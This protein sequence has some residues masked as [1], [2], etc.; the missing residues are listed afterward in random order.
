MKNNEEK[1]QKKI[2]SGLTEIEIKNSREHYGTNLITSQKQ[3]SFFHLLLQSLGDPI[4]K[5]LLIALG[6]K[7]IFLLKQFDWFE[8]IGIVI[9][10]FV[11]SFISTISEYGSEKAF[12]KL[13]EESLK[14]KCRVRR[15][16]QVEE[17]P[18]DEVV[19][20]DIVLLE[21]GDKIPAD[22]KIIKGEL[23]VDESSLN[24]ETKEAKKIAVQHFSDKGTSQNYV[25]RGTVVY[26]KEAVMLVTQVGNETIFG[27]LAKE[28]QEKQP[29]SPLKIRLRG[30]AKVISKIGY[31]GSALVAFSYLFSVIVIE[32]QFN[33]DKITAM[34][35]NFPVI[36]GHILYALTLCVTIIVVAVPEGLPMMI[37]LVLSSNMKRMLKNNVLVRKLT[38]IETAGNLN[39]LFTDKTGTLT[40]G[41]LEV[42]QFYTGSR[43]EY[44]SEFELTKYSNFY[45]IVKAS[46]VCNN[47]SSFNSERTKIVGGNITDRAILEFAGI[48][49]D[50][51][52]QKL[53]TIPFDSKNKYSATAI[54]MNGRVNLIKGAPEKILSACTSYYEEN[55]KKSYIFP[56]YMIENKVK[57]MTSRGIRAVAFATSKNYQITDLKDLTFVGIAFIKDDIREEAKEGIQLVHDAHIQTVMITGDN[58]DTAISIGKE[59][60]LLSTPDDIVLTSSELAKKTDSEVKQLLP[61]LRIVARSLPQDKSRLVRLSQELNLVVGM[62]GDGVNDAP[63]LKKA[64]VGFAMGSGT[65][66]SKE[67]SDIVILDDN[68]L[69]ISK[70]ILFGRTIFKSIRKFIILQLTINACAIG[71][72]I[73]GPF[74]GIDT[75]VTVIQ[76]LW[77]N[78]VMDTL[79][80]LAFAF[81]PPLLEYMNEYPKKKNEAIMNKYMMN[82]II[83]NGVYSCLL[84][85]AF[86][87]V[88]MIKTWFRFGANQIY[89]MTAFFGLFIFVD[90]FNGFNAR[91]HR[92]NIFAH[93]KQ[94]KMFIFIMMLIV[95]VQVILIYYG[96]SLFRTAGLTIKEFAVMLLL[97]STVIPVDWLRKLILRK[98]GIIGGV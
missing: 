41:K 40:K 50:L 23:S 18:I 7:M 36:T 3:D 16:G 91:T 35:T 30:L 86:L 15:N 47:A 24:G 74:I 20:G 63:A 2:Y 6:I 64:D 12:A 77:I 33:L 54:E 44:H 62:T 96:G 11:A 28:I 60:G 73:I 57:S 10:I 48:N 38:G 9:A 69:S 90:I 67:A 43:K 76:M 68:F 82:Q 89:L 49:V 14:L 79:A 70:A 65:E 39:I 84:C 78:M 93:L 56:K 61:N 26:E 34:I 17:I 92:L 46:M 98:Q 21:A 85:I 94:N 58:K 32:N 51:P 37:T 75:P 66:V 83:V 45:P 27:K 80:G 31:I 87:K 71:L 42:I 59:V 13:Q 8:T 1:I 5:I 4:I 25:Y 95:L 72:S 19:V 22:G 81:E 97:A 29:E 55:G 88:P 53:N 52:Y